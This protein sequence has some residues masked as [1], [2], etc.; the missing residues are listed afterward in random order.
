MVKGVRE[1]SVQFSVDISK[2]SDRT[3]GPSREQLHT[4]ENIRR[5]FADFGVPVTWFVPS[6]SSP[7][8][9]WLVNNLGQDEIGWEPQVNPS[10]APPRL[11][12]IKET[13]QRELAT[14]VA[15]GQAI[16][17]VALPESWARPQTLEW[18]SD[19]GVDVLRGPLSV[20]LLKRLQPRMLRQDL[21]Q[22]PVAAT[23]P[24]HGRGI[25]FGALDLGFLAKKALLRALQGDQ[26]VHIAMLVNE[27]TLAIDRIWNSLSRLL[28]RVRHLQQAARLK[29]VTMRQTLVL[30]PGARETASRSILR[31]A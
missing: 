31:A 2:I 23:Y 12:E 8:T 21:W 30:I 6:A 24:G 14:F 13:I 17:S 20:T 5:R 28:Q 11:T 7:L 27:R 26:A 25:G 4:L 16:Q 9:L 19:G 10:V 29:C 18:L 3:C 22:V 15:A 1:G